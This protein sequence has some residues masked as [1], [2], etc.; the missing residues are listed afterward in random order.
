LTVHGDRLAHP[1]PNAPP[2]II[3]HRHPWPAPRRRVRLEDREELIMASYADRLAKQRAENAALLAQLRELD[4]AAA[5]SA[6]A[7]TPAAPTIGDLL[8]EAKRLRAGI[9]ARAAQPA[10][11]KIQP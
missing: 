8:D 5:V 6:V 11:T 4:P 9:A 10:T 1:L 3:R 7:K 2:D